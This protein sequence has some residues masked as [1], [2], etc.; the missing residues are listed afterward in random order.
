MPREIFTMGNVKA[1]SARE[2]AQNAQH[3]K[4]LADAVVRSAT[5]RNNLNPTAANKAKLEK[6]KS[7]ATTATKDAG[8]AAQAVVDTNK[9]KKGSAEPAAPVPPKAK[10]T[11]PVVKYTPP[12][13]DNVVDEDNAAK[14]EK[15][16]DDGKKDDGKKN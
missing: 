14:D 15:D 10:P 13:E 3:K 4:E 12:D 9:K 2:K 5:A 1:T 16:K 11:P 8:K 7:A 6:A